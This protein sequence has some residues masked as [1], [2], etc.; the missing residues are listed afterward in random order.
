MRRLLV[1]IMVL[2]TFAGCNQHSARKSGEYS[3]FVAGH[4]Y[5][6]PNATN[7]HLHPAFVQQFET[8]RN[9]PGI[10]FGIFNGDLVRNSTPENWDSVEVDLAKLRIP[11]FVVP[12]NHD[13][14]NRPLFEQKFGD[15]EKGFR[16]YSFFKQHE[17][18]F[19]LL[20]GN[21]D[22][23]SITEKQLEFFKNVISEEAPAAR[24]IFVFVHELI[25][26]DESNEFS[27]VKLNWPPY[28]PDTTNYWGE[29]QPLLAGTKKPV[30]LVAGDLGASNKASALMFAEK[31]NLTYVASGMG[32]NKDENFLFVNVA[33]NGKVEFEVFALRG[34]RGRLGK[35]ESYKVPENIDLQ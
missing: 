9:Y 2:L 12:G 18:L 16:T 15:P 31:G 14:Y 8:I 30:F 28:T 7:L 20:D 17:D 29:I 24:N 19:I 10:A 6:N 26:W 35:I 25:W 13:T 23:W 22:K 5:G 27:S 21:L 11:Y 4:T 32:G 33:E 1:L 34:D 3:F